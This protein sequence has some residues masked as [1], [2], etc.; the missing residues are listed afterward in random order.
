M[1]GS[2]NVKGLATYQSEVPVLLGKVESLCGEM[3][4]VSLGIS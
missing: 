3:V 1:T 4:V 2:A